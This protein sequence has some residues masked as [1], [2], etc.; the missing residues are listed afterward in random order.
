MS[1]KN[2]ISIVSIVLALV[3]IYL[4]INYKDSNIKNN[5]LNIEPNKIFSKEENSTKITSSLNKQIAKPINSSPVKILSADAKAAHLKA[6]ENGWSTIVDDFEKNSF[7]NSTMSDEEINKL[8][9]LAI[10]NVTETDL[11]RLLKTDCRPTGKYTS[12]LII[13]G[14][15]RDKDGNLNENEI[16][17]KLQIL[18]KEGLLSLKN[19]YDENLKEDKFGKIEI[20]LFDKAV[21][22]GANHVIDYVASIGSSPTANRNPIFTQV[23]G[24]P[25]IETVQKLIKMGYT[26][27]HSTLTYIN[28]YDF[29]NKYPEIYTLLNK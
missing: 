18:N 4:F 3:C 15:I 9:D 22:L 11:K 16:I 25:N 20:T 12:N 27:D 28:N 7:K 19:T 21:S 26:A 10:I 5:S 2:I 1:K 17:K 29:Q 13:N 6:L 24:R 23:A 14:K 8:C